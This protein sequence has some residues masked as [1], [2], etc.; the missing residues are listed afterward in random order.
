MPLPDL[1]DNA[2]T[3]F[4]GWVSDMYEENY[5]PKNFLATAESNTGLFDANTYYKVIA[6]P[7]GRSAPANRSFYWFWFQAKTTSL[8]H[9]LVKTYCFMYNVLG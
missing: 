8:E 5:L 1:L 4:K 9:F 3:G 6:L 7:L 2:E